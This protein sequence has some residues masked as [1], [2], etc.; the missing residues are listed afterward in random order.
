MVEPHPSLKLMRRGS[1]QRLE[2][3]NIF[4][5]TPQLHGN[6]YVELLIKGW[7]GNLLDALT[8]LKH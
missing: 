2:G 8:P 5:L 3:Q 4:V 6:H 7:R 1:N